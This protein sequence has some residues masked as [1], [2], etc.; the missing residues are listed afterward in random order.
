[1]V[2]IAPGEGARLNPQQPNYGDAQW[3]PVPPG[4]G[5]PPPGH[6]VTVGYPMPQPPRPPRRKIPLI[7]FVLAVPLLVVGLGLYIWHGIHNDDPRSVAQVR[8]LRAGDCIDP[9][10]DADSLSALLSTAGLTDTID[11]KTYYSIDQSSWKSFTGVICVAE[12]HPS[13]QPV[14]SIIKK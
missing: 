12:A 10:S 1:M 5:F 3:Q 9:F 8:D 6:G 7:V 14:Q 4:P 13:H 2:F 11:L